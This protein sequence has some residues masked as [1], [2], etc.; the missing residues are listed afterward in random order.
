MNS[1]AGRPGRAG[2]CETAGLGGSQYGSPR[3]KSNGQNRAYPG[4]L[5]VSAA[6]CD[7]SL[8]P[9]LVLEVAPPPCVHLRESAT[10]L[11]MVSQV[12]LQQVDRLL[13]FAKQCS[14]ESFV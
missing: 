3:R 8:E 13:P 10:V 2:C 14:D 5:R 12:F 1:W 9:R 7:Q 11:W 6:Q 4:K